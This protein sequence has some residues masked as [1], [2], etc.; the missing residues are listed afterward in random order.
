MN[1]IAPSFYGTSVN[2][3]ITVVQIIGRR[4][5]NEIAYEGESRNKLNG[6]TFE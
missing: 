6:D 2:E 3:Q 5:R 4:R 1:E